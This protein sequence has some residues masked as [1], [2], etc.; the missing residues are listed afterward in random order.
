LCNLVI[1]RAPWEKNLSL[2]AKE[3]RIPKYFLAIKAK[4]GNLIALDF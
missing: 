3:A 1:I 2:G 4:A